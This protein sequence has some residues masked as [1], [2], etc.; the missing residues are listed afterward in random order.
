MKKAVM[1]A[2]FVLPFLL[3]TIGYVRLGN[4]V[5][6][7]MYGTVLL[8][9]MNPALDGKNFFVEFARW[10]GP[11]VTAGG[12]I[13]MLQSVFRTLRSYFLCFYPDATAVY[14]DN[15]QDEILVKNM[16]H[17]FSAGKTLCKRAA[18]HILLFE[19]DMD[20]LYFY[21]QNRAFLES[22]KTYMKIEETD[23]FLMKKSPVLYFNL[24]EITAR[25]YWK[26]H[27]LMDYFEAGQR[28][29]NIAII[30]FDQMGENILRF[31]LLNNIYYT[32]QEI[33]YHVWGDHYV[34][35]KFHAQMKLMNKDRI[36]YHRGEPAEDPEL[37]KG[38][39]RIILTQEGDFKTLE[40]YLYLC[41]EQEIHFYNPSGNFAEEVYAYPKFSVFGCLEDI[42]T[43]EVIKTDKLYRLAKELNY[44][45]DCL[46]NNG[47]KE[48]AEKEKHMAAIWQELDGFTKGSNISA[49]DYHEIRLMI[50]A[51]HPEQTLKSAQEELSFYEHIRWCRFHYLNYWS[52]GVP[53]NGKNKDAKSKIH[54]CLV[55]YEELSREDQVK[56]YET[57]KLLTEFMPAAEGA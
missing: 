9:V 41:R 12:I 26:K 47:G 10:T 20:N 24:S 45:Y 1:A 37:L 28:K 5:L 51:K 56:D 30:G 18:N 14:C 22:R 42:L 55:P 29:I 36:I 52:Y 7:A 19:K 4:D 48:Y 38:M 54:K 16:K 2:A 53:E 21:E 50:M 11:I 40:T 6:D 43:D 13:L 3:G 39:D 35:E 17:G 34:F 44:R 33:V 31:G 46:Y 32:E 25:Q 49:A 8:Y 27:H 23:T 15:G 57:I